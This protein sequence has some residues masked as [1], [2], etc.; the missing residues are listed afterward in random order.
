MENT[1]VDGNCTL[2]EKPLA[3]AGDSAEH[4]IPNS[5]GGRRKVRSFICRLCNSRSG[6]SWDAEIWRQFSH[7]AMLHGVERDRGELPVIKI[8]T[9]N[10]TRYR[11]LSD[12]SMTPEH[13]SY[14][15]E[16]G[17]GGG[18]I[19]FSA[20]DEGEARRMVKDIAKKFPG[21]DVDRMLQA[22]RTTESKL[23]SPVTF[24]GEFGGNQAN[25]SMVK[26]A[27][28]LAV[29]IG[30]RP[31][32]CE[33]AVAYLRSN[34]ATEPCAAFYVRDLVSNRPKTHAFNCVAIV[35][36]PSRRT[37][38]GYIE[39]FSMWRMVVILSNTYN[40]EPTKA[41]YAFD[42]SNGRE[43]GI[44]VDLNLSE[45]ELAL[46]LANGALTRESFS[47]AMHAGFDVIYKRSLLR[48]WEREYGKAIEHA[49]ARMGIPENGEISSDRAQEFTTFVLEYLQPTIAKMVGR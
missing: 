27:L 32:Q 11:L 25:H 12:G 42:P 35:G 39:Y 20:R 40:G 1:N 16:K 22:L 15:V 38:L 34:T 13:P 46:V 9:V 48:P 36:D 21:A 29:A 4:I 6:D 31:R 44:E 18:R 8:Q 19:S 17:E 14:S 26:T 41:I 30:V 37:L 45:E 10:G 23:D 43:V 7:V 47:S 24:S 33:R 28:A 49:C 2:C 3:V 5:I